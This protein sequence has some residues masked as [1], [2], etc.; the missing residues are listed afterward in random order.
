MNGQREEWSV[1][2]NKND[3]E[4]RCQDSRWSSLV[5]EPKSAL[6]EVLRKNYNYFQNFKI[7]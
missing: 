2:E 7:I 4:G 3:E 6:E 1:E 5:E